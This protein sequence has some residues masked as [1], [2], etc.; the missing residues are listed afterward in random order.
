MT[1]LILNSYNKPTQPQKESELMDKIYA[2]T[3][4]LIEVGIYREE[5]V[6]LHNE[7][8]DGRLLTIKTRYS[9]E[10]Y[11]PIDRVRIKEQKTT[12]ESYKESVTEFIAWRLSTVRCSKVSN[13]PKWIREF[14]Q[15]KAKI[16]E[17]EDIQEIIEK[18]L[19]RH[20]LKQE[21]LL[22]EGYA[23]ISNRLQ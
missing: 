7:Y 21:E 1:T 18:S 12:Y 10:N 23:R 9:R 16:N 17:E 4:H 6:T 5:I 20:T 13:K 15:S 8:E 2:E 19:A 11:K 22:R 3:F 14:L